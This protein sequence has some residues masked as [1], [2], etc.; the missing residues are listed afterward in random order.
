MLLLV[1]DDESI[2]IQVG[3]VV[4]EVDGLGELVTATTAAQARSFLAQEGS[5][6]SC[7]LVDHNLAD[8]VAISLIQEVGLSHPLVPA[9][10]LAPQRTIDVV[11]LA[12][13]AGARAVLAVP[14]SLEDL[15]SRLAP[16]IAWS[17]AA[18]SGLDAVE[19]VDMSRRMGTVTAVVGAKG[20][21]GSSTLTLL[22][23]SRLARQGRTCVVD[24]DLRGGDLAAMTGIGVRRSIIDLV[25]IAAE[26]SAREIA[27]VIYPLPGGLSLLPAPV[28]GERGEEM[29][30]AATR[31][32]ITALRYQFDHV[33]LDCGSRLD[34]VL[35]M[36]LDCADRVLVVASQD[37][38]SLRRTR[39]LTAAM[40][41]L[42]IARGASIGL[43]M[44]KINRNRE[45]QPAAAEK[46]VSVQLLGSI[47]DTTNH[48]ELIVNTSSILSLQTPVM[49]KA[50][51]RV[52]A[53]ALSLTGAVASASLPPMQGTRAKRS[54]RR[55]RRK[56]AGADEGQLLVEFPA[57][58]ALATLVLLACV[59]ILSYGVS[60]I[61]AT[62]AAEE[63]ARAY[64]VGMSTSQVHEE[65]EDRLPAIWAQGVSVSQS[66]A[67]Q[68]SVTV[69]VPSVVDLHATAT[70]GIVWEE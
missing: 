51:D 69:E 14:V 17:H 56:R 39:Q 22:L 66:G 15:T 46:I 24:L 68:V 28:Q 60:W 36:G 44:N 37:V 12:V 67:S 43:V 45:I 21:V 32:I 38:Q 9:V 53:R 31:Q 59:Q 27:E 19:A 26:I 70:T 62:H 52:L 20:G 47:P 35:A 58:F 65:V 16:V 30:E 6:V 40:E 54:T 5:T 48:I 33:V 11:D 49:L 4:A 55:A 50:V 57:V 41:R 34:A 13:S 1:S 10:L 25:D 64:A 2:R 8:N 23:A 7:M 42:S 18:R 63:A 61:Y 29:T 3:A